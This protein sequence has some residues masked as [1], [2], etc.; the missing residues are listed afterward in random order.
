MITSMRTERF[1][2]EGFFS[3]YCMSQPVMHS[4]NLWSVFGP[5]FQPHMSLSVAW[6]GPLPVR[7]TKWTAYL[8]CSWHLSASED[9]V[10]T[11][12]IIRRLKPKYLEIV[13]TH[14][15]CLYG[16]PKISYITLCSCVQWGGKRSWCCCIDIFALRYVSIL[17]IQL[18]FYCISSILL[19]LNQVNEQTIIM[20]R[21]LS[22]WWAVRELDWFLMLLVMCLMW[23]RSPDDCTFFV[24]IQGNDTVCGSSL[25]WYWY[26]TIFKS[27]KLVGHNTIYLERIRTF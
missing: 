4:I 14:C 15:N 11:Q 20:H 19:N 1:S 3:A 10:H 7:D 25:L 23:L 9:A 18:E 12:C 16:A 22:V 24:C 21:W 17:L 2:S 6:M 5:P 13:C 26:K 8:F 27:N